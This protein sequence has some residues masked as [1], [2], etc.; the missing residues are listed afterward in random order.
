[1]G[2]IRASPLLLL[3]EVTSQEILWLPAVALLLLYKSSLFLA[4][5]V[6]SL[7]CLLLTCCSLPPPV[8]LEVQQ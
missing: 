4:L 5:H 1:M 8:L 3:F 2:L 7:L 6:L